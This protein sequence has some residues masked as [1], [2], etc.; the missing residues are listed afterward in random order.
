M[1][2]EKDKEPF[3]S[4]ARRLLSELRGYRWQRGRFV[5][6]E[7]PI[8]IG[9]CG[10]S[11]TTL[12][13]VILDSH[14][15]VCCGPETNL[16]VSKTRLNPGSPTARKLAE[17]FD[18]S[19]E[20]MDDLLR[21]SSSRAQFIDRFFTTVRAQ[22]GKPFWSD[23]T[24]RNVQVLPYI[25]EH[26]PQARFIH[27][28]RDGRDVVCS[29]R[30]HPRFRMI[31]G[32]PVKLDTWNPIEDCVARWV[33]DVSLGLRYR[34][35]PGS[36]ELRYEDLVRR[37]EPAL[38][39]LFEFLGLPWE[40]AVLKFNE[41]KTGSR[42]PKRFAQNPEAAKPLQSSAVGRWRGDLDEKDLAYVMRKAGTLLRELGYTPDDLEGNVPASPRRIDR[43][44]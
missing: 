14:S 43:T 32:Q 33:Q 31:D 37:P 10:R 44:G 9:G 5:S 35:D 18:L 27:M 25:F 16:F 24:P 38:R 28:I 7:A 6:A 30:T 13:R 29:L 11:G 1:A 34:D 41:V 22:A 3:W 19:H 40:P 2:K 8:L 12:L 17:R 26:F 42:D 39:P 20:T 15:Q 36:L 4:G 23:K 21:R